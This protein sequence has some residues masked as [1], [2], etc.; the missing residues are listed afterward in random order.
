MK[1]SN[2]IIQ[3]TSIDS[4]QQM[5]SNIY[6]GT[7]EGKVVYY[8]DSG[9]DNGIWFYADTKED[10]AERKANFMRLARTME[11]NRAWA[12][13]YHA[14][15][16]RKVPINQVKNIQTERQNYGSEQLAKAWEK[17]GIKWNTKI[18]QD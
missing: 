14:V 1:T 11:K 10:K 16:C 8:K 3:S 9:Y 18:K 12:I 5:A 13:A 4:N 7:L 2:F 17:M 15:P 6:Y